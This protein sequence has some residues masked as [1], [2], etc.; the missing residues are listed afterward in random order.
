[1]Y[2]INKVL[3]NFKRFEESLVLV[4]SA[5][6]FISFSCLPVILAE[7]KLCQKMIWQN[8]FHA[9]SEEMVWCWNKSVTN[10]CFLMKQQLF[11]LIWETLSQKWFFIPGTWLAEKGTESFL[12]DMTKMKKK[13][14]SITIIE[15]VLLHFDML[16]INWACHQAPAET[17][18]R[19]W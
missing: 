2:V 17:Q 15:Q 11:F 4:D 9:S 6:S 16:V 14:I 1:M 8:L 13:K 3:L 18:L 12:S 10:L 5:C 7:E 19:Y